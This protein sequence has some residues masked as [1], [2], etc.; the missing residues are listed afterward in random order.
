MQAL[1]HQKK[2]FIHNAI[3]FLA[4]VLPKHITQLNH[5]D[6]P[7]FSLIFHLI[8]TQSQ[9]TTTSFSFPPLSRLSGQSHSNPL[10]VV[11]HTPLLACGESLSWAGHVLVE[12]RRLFIDNA[13]KRQESG[14][15]AKLDGN[16][17]IA[18][19][20]EDGRGQERD[21]WADKVVVLAGDG[22]EHDE[23]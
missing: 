16:D 22:A 12:H 14:F 4:L 3:A 17:R 1:L 21:M 11:S 7:N 23:S 13:E 18:D 9:S 6:T 5:T 10:E 8:T 2:F 19:G 20:C 15:S